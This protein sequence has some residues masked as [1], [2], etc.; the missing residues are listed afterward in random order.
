M[1][2]RK[3][4]PTIKSRLPDSYGRGRAKSGGHEKPIQPIPVTSSPRC[5]SGCFVSRSVLN[6]NTH[7][8]GE[9]MRTLACFF[10]SLAVPSSRQGERKRTSCSQD[11]KYHAHVVSYL[12]KK[13]FGSFTKVSMRNGNIQCACS[14][15]PTRGAFKTTANA[16]SLEDVQISAATTSDV[17]VPRKYIVSWV[18]GLCLGAGPHFSGVYSSGV[19]G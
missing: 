16:P 10:S 13:T 7:M 18:G 19:L 1:I 2:L 11:R 9:R 12:S 4:N 17:V 6:E 5:L 15:K 14:I 8:K 3:K